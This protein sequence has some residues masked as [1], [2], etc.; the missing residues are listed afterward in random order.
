MGSGFS[1]KDNDVTLEEQLNKV[2]SRAALVSALP[3]A[4]TKGHQ[5]MNRV[6]RCARA[7]P[8]HPGPVPV[9]A[10]RRRSSVGS[11][12]HGQR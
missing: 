6:I 10:A 7:A 11:R 4:H 5:S 2:E 9:E 12:A 8:P 1:E 3:A